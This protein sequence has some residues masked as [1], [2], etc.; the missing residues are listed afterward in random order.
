MRLQQIQQ[1]SWAGSGISPWI[2]VE[3]TVNSRGIA[4]PAKFKLQGGK[5]F[6]IFYFKFQ[7]FA[8]R[9]MVEQGLNL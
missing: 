9:K 1:I 7:D 3:N 5:L 4:K 2:K 6:K 8:V